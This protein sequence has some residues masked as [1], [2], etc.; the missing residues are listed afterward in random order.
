[1]PTHT[2][3]PSEVKYRRGEPYVSEAT[4]KKFLGQPRGIY[5]GFIPSVA[6]GSL[7]L[8][9]D[10]DPTYKIS[11]ARVKSGLDLV[12]VDVVL[13]SAVTLDFDGHDFT[14]DPTVYVMVRASQKLGSPTTTNV[15]TRGTGPADATEQLICVVTKPGA[16]LV[17]VSDQPVNQDSPF[18]WATAPLGYGFM[19]DGAVEQL[20][21]AVAMVA[22]VQAARLDLQGVT[23]PFPDGLHDRI[24]A[25]LDSTAIAGRLGFALRVLRGE[26]K[27]VPATTDTINVSGSFTETIRTRPPVLTLEANGS[28]TQAGVITNSDVEGRNVCFVMEVG[29]NERLIDTGNQNKVVYGR[30]EFSEFDLGTTGGT[31]V[32]SSVSTTV[33]GSGGTLDFT[34]P[35][36]VKEGDI[37]LAPDG[38]Y[39]EVTS[40]GGPGTLDLTTIPSVGGTPASQL[41]RRWNLKT[42]TDDG[43]GG[44]TPFSVLAG[45]TIRFFFGAYF[46]HEDSIHDSRL[47]MFEGGEEPPLPNAAVGVEGTILMHPGI[48]DALG[49]A[50]RNVQQAG[51]TVGA[52]VPVHSINFSSGTSSVPGVAD[53]DA[54][55]PTGPTGPS[56][57]GPGPAGPPGPTGGGF[58]TFSDTYDA[59]PTFFPTVG[60]AVP[61]HNPGDIHTHT[62]NFGS[63]IKFLYGNMARWDCQAV[64]WDGDDTFEI[65]DIRITGA[66]FPTGTEG[67]IETQVR[68]PGTFTAVAIYRHYLNGAG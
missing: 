42:F 26:D 24:V 44:Q 57:T 63:P 5:L 14:A 43:A 68:V 62:V 13:D 12:D 27:T 52:G 7:I 29:R 22:E 4:N 30:L 40:I 18:A 54:A 49:G 2:F 15:F 37:L 32:F 9:L 61:A 17:V 11:F 23:W 16:D 65:I 35:T 31:L 55:G 56:G 36:Q 50:V 8:T 48:T 21:A 3:Q 41:R 59:G 1:M 10:V 28:E 38:L 46:T 33:T 45:T 64:V 25:D 51:A 20:I 60:P 66:G 39:H 67:T 47:L 53:I 58:D 34:D 6:S 19:R